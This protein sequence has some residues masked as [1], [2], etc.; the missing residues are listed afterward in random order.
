MCGISGIWSN[1]E[2]AD[3]LAADSM[4]DALAHRG[5]DGRGTRVLDRGRLILGHRRLAIIDLSAAASQPMCNEDGSIWLVFN[6]EIYN[7]PDLRRELE[8]RG[9]AFRSRSDSETI[10]HAYEEWGSQ[11]VHRL[12][13]IF[14]FAIYDATARSLFL[15]RDP[16]GV[17]PLYY[18]AGRERFVFASQPRSILAS[19]GFRRSVDADAFDLYLAYGNVPGESCIFRGIE[20]LAPGHWLLLGDGRM[21]RERYWSPT[22][23]PV[24]RDAAEAEELV[25]S[26]LAESVRTQAVSDVP[27]GSLLSGGVDSTLV[28]SLLTRDGRR[29]LQTFTIGFDEPESDESSHAREVAAALGTRHHEKTLGREEA[30]WLLPDIVEASD[31]PFHL[32]GLFPYLALAKLVQATGNKVVLGG[33]GADELF[34]GYRWYESFSQAMASP[35]GDSVTGRLRRLLG[36]R[37]RGATGPVESFFRYHASFDP[38]SLRNLVGARRAPTADPQLYAPLARAWHSEHPPVVAAQLADLA[39]FLVDHCLTKVD[40]MSMA[41]GVEVRVPFLDVPLVEAALRI[42]H[43]LV[44]RQ[45]ERKA[46]LKDAMR[47]YFPTGM[48]TARKKGFSSPLGPWLRAGM[49][50]AGD[51]LLQE[52]SLV[53]RGLLD[54]RALRDGYAKLDASRQLTLISAELWSRRWLDD[55]ATAAGVFAESVLGCQPGALGS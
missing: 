28:T 32:N 8:R 15:A 1:G 31:E 5:P 7:Y 19:E 36:A 46:L 14:A 35:G 25:R 42:D 51:E 24:I 53:G 47:A 55:D 39:C 48:D 6:G 52:G 38:P 17:K 43:A 9:H 2:P 50:T 49:A 41:C 11:C 10:V 30:C 40:R 21:Q 18:H 29:D 23:D 44:F 22:Y 16:I 45:Q 13:G 4:V 54:G 26:K 12:R 37:T 33:D 27:I 34:A 3:P 20:K